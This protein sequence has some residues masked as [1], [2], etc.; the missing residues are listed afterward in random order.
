MPTSLPQRKEVPSMSAGDVDDFQ[1]H[2]PYKKMT[3]STQSKNKYELLDS[4]LKN[5]GPDSDDDDFDLTDEQSKF[6]IPLQT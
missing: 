5:L 1:D 4:V 2:I 3:Y 6:G